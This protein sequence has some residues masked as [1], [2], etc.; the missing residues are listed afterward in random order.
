MEDIFSKVKRKAQK[1]TESIDQSLIDLKKSIDRMEKSEAK[2]NL[3]QKANKSLSYFTER[4]K[5]DINIIEIPEDMTYEKLSTLLK[6]IKKLFELITDISR[7]TIPKFQRD[8]QAEIKD[9]HYYTRKLGQKGG[10]LDK[11]LREKYKKIREAENLINKLPKLFALKNN[12]ENAKNSINEIGN[13]KEDVAIQLESLKNELLKF[14]DHALFKKQSDLNNDLFN[15]KIDINDNLKFKKALKKL[16]VEV[17]RGNIK[18]R[19]ISIDDIKDFFK[20]PI[21]NLC[22]DSKDLRKLSILL[23]QLRITLESNE[24]KLKTTKKES[25]IEHINQIL[26]GNELKEN[27]EKYK[28]LQEEISNLEKEINETGLSKKIFQLKEKIA[29]ASLKKDH[30]ENDFKK[31]NDD[32]LSYLKKL[33]EEREKFSKMVEGITDER[34]K[35]VITFSF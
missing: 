33:K 18:L 13:E 2:E 12:I 17:E 27:I 14:E 31:K 16:R 3:D 23:V 30:L 28:H 25:T 11:F 35:I 26:S 22:K 15:L 32:Y 21:V 34:I 24:L 20:D 19:N 5:K 29:S 9:L 6:E 8:F 4:V 1:L 10:I 7:K